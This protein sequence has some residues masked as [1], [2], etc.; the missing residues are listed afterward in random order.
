MSAPKMEDITLGL[1]DAGTEVRGRKHKRRVIL[2]YAADNYGG[3]S[4][5]MTP[6][7]ARALASWLLRAADLGVE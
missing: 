5:V 3:T 1:V 4:A 7:E 6:D 2:L